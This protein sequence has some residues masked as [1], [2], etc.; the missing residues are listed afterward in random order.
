M[1]YQPDGCHRQTCCDRANAGRKNETATGTD[2]ND[3]KHDLQA[4]EQDGLE[5]GE[6]R[7]PIK[8]GL[9]TA[10]L[11][12]QFCRF[13]CECRDLIVQRHDA[14]VAQ[15]RLAQPSHAKQQQQNSDCKLQHVQRNEV[16]DWAERHYDKYQEAKA[17]KSAKSC[18]PP[19]AN[20]GH[21]K[22]YSQCF[23]GFD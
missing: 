11:L 12:A 4:L 15:D 22:H 16:E 23:H 1:D 8:A 20:G 7:E 6:A 19:A 10:S 14:G 18:G 3:N 17:G 5:A 9:V 21:G 2:R 13:G